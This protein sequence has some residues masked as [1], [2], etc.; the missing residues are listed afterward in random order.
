MT[1]NMKLHASPFERIK[2]GKKTIE[3]RLF[4]EKRQQ[5]KIGDEIIFMNSSTGETL[6]ATVVKL[7]VFKDF[8]QLYKALP[9]LQ[10][11]YTAENV[12]KATPADMEEY[13]SLAEQS[14]YGVVGIELSL[15]KQ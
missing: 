6:S 9:L 15:S 1:H 8:A 13:Y 7:H 11:G 12:D 3:L 2:S 5:I 10:C 4:D 14:K